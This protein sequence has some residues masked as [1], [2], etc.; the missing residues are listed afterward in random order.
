MKGDRPADQHSAGGVVL[1]DGEVCVIVPKKRTANGKKANALPKGHVDPGET[2]IEAA[3]REVREETGLVCEPVGELGESATGTAATVAR[4]TSRSL[5]PFRVRPAALDDHDDEVESVRWMPMEQALVALTSPE[6]ARWCAE[7]AAARTLTP[8]RAGPQLL[9]DGLRRRAKRGRKTAT[10]R[11]GD[12]SGKYRKN[13]AVLVTIG[14]QHSPRERIFEAVI[15]Q[16]EVMKVWRALPAR[17]RARQPRVPPP[18]GADQLP[19][20]DLRARGRRWT[21]P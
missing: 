5:L 6:S 14:Y 19:R 13:Q 8:E 9:F 15:D 21:T 20:A 2:P 4:S 7:A 3:T 10:I 18:R 11:L 1:R 12:K 16:V 17:H